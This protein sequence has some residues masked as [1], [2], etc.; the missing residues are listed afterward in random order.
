MMFRIELLIHCQTSMVKP[1]KFGNGKIISSLYLSMLGLK[2]IHKNI[3]RHTADTIVSLPNPKQLVIVDTSDLM[4]TIRQSIYILSIITTEM[5]K[6]KAY[7][8]TYCIM[9]NGGNM[10]NVS[11]YGSLLSVRVH[12]GSDTALSP[13]LRQVISCC[14]IAVW[15][16]Q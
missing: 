1:L 4:M 2:L 16:H 11:K 10:L 8:P 9:D 6:L 15:A 5:G 3:E 12:F 13:I 14:R 7:S